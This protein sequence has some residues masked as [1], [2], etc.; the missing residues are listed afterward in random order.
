M[1]R[2]TIID[3]FSDPDRTQAQRLLEL[4][5]IPAKA[6][7]AAYFAPR[8]VGADLCK[9]LSERME[10]SEV[11][12]QEVRDYAQTILQ[13]DTQIP[14]QGPKI[15]WG[16]P[17]ADYDDD[18]TRNA[19]NGDATITMGASSSSMYSGRRS[20]TG[21]L[22]SGEKDLATLARLK[23]V[24]AFKK[25]RTASPLFA[26]HADLVF[27]HVRQ[28]GV[29]GMGII[30][31]IVD[32]RLGREAALKLI[33]HDRA[34][35]LEVWRFMREA[36]IMARLDHP[37]IPPVYEAGTDSDGQHY[38]LMR[39]IK[40]VPFDECIRR[41]HRG[42]RN[43]QQLEEYLNILVKVGEAI[44]FAH[45]EGI[46]HRDLK[47]NNIMV[48]QFGEAMVLD[49][50]LARDTRASDAK[51][52]E[53]GRPIDEDP[54][55]DLVEEAEGQEITQIGAVMGTVGYMPPEQARGHS[56]DERAD[57]FALG[58]VLSKLL[59]N[60]APFDG[61]GTLERLRATQ[62]NRVRLPVD[63]DP[64][65]SPELNAIARAALDP[66]P[67]FRTKSAHAF[68][69]DIKAYLSGYDV[70][71]YRYR[72]WEKWLRKIKRNPVPLIG[73]V[74][75]VGFIGVLIQLITVTQAASEQIRLAQE[76]EDESK[77]ARKAEARAVKAA[78]EARANEKKA[79][80]A[81]AAAKKAAE[82]A[83]TARDNALKDQERAVAE[84]KR[85]TKA[86]ED[87]LRAQS[88][89]QEEKRNADRN[90]ANLF[91]EKADRAL[92]QDDILHAEAFLSQSLSLL[93]SSWSTRRRYLNTQIGGARLLWTSPKSD[94][95]T[96]LAITHATPD[97][98]A[99][100]ATAGFTGPIGIWDAQAGKELYRLEGHKAEILSLDID[101]SG[102]YLA[103]GDAKGKIIIWDLVRGLEK[104]RLG[105][106]SEI[107][108]QRLHFVNDNQLI[109]GGL[110]KV[111][112]VNRE[113][114]EQPFIT[115]WDV[116]ERTEI[117][118]FEKPKNKVR[119]LAVHPDGELLAT[120]SRD[121][122]LNIWDLT[123]GLL[124]KTLLNPAPIIDLEFS[125]NGKVFVSADS[126]GRIAIFNG[127]IAPITSFVS[128]SA[129]VIQ[130]LSLG[131]DGRHL[132]AACQGGSV[133]HWSG[134]NWKEAQRFKRHQGELRDIAVIHSGLVAS[135][136]LDGLRL[137]ATGNKQGQF[138]S[139]GHQR[140][141]RAVAFSPNGGLIATASD[142]GAVRL[143]N[144]KT[145]RLERLLPKQG[146]AV[147]AVAFHPEGKILA[148]GSTDRLIR[149]WRVN[150]GRLLGILKGHSQALT[151]LAFSKDGERLASSCSEEGSEGVKILIW[152]VA[153]QK[154]I[155][156]L[157]HH[158]S[159][160]LAVAFDPTGR[161]LAS[162]GKDRVI[163]LWDFQTRRQLIAL[164]G[165]QNAVTSLSFGPRGLVLAS[166]SFDKSVRLWNVF[167]GIALGQLD[168]HK[169]EVTGVSFS[170]DGAFLA[171]VSHDKALRLWEVATRKSIYKLSGHLDEVTGVAFSP[172][173]GSIATVSKDRTLKLWEYSNIRLI[174]HR[175]D[176]LDVAF[177]PSG[178][179]IVSASNDR[180]LR[181]WSSKTGASRDILAGRQR[182][183]GRVEYSPDGRL[184]AWA[185]GNNTVRLTQRGAKRNIPTLSG[186]ENMVLGIAFSPDNKALASTSLDKT[187]RLWS[188]KSG[189][190]RLCFKGHTKAV[191]DVA[192]SPTNDFFVTAS[193]DRT[194]RVWNSKSGKELGRLIGHRDAVT[195][196]DVA[197][198]NSSIVIASGSDDNTVRLWSWSAKKGGQE[199]RLFRVHSAP[200]KFVSFSPGGELLASG[201]EDGTVRVFSV[202]AGRELLSLSGHN[203]KAV[204]S[205]RFGLRNG[206]LLLASAGE[207][208]IVRLWNVEKTIGG[209]AATLEMDDKKKEENARAL[210]A[211]AGLRTG[212][213]VRD[214]EL[215]PIPQ[216]YLAPGD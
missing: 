200:V 168:G 149:L 208:R 192:F 141:L 195:S 63:R 49:W 178:N 171:S 69:Q 41:Y 92:A 177:N 70:S 52:Q 140:I 152:D 68:V 74:I 21:A 213:R 146:N 124:I 184:V 26:P 6:L 46:I 54:E 183:V 17:D 94:R 34:S 205:V 130:A 126:S 51:E 50:G 38:L 214:L 167:S 1:S 185:N 135:V 71:V 121:K 4:Q 165:H 189:K 155:E 5:L 127:D 80:Q 96:V 169:E 190:E 153:D 30:H 133:Q 28:I 85:A 162:A 131:P 113:Y 180:T 3:L 216:N 136:G 156:G 60:Q 20:L 114:L 77:K 181:F 108:V 206:Q 102:N 115:L 76:A 81:Q 95:L 137:W 138:H 87:A 11:E 23:M 210:L 73:T 66:N 150:D 170:P 62:E 161:L 203:G 199:T 12:A 61:Q 97:R 44:A 43:S 144:S 198:I 186:H 79:M 90:L 106:G 110:E 56:V 13:H 57:V 145:H 212:F 176:V 204:R 112:G 19:H 40:G 22:K 72:M 55:K 104:T 59:T 25:M 18:I 164:S 9:I 154:I 99:L 116:E 143:W 31:Q 129:N 174:G 157:T 86:A 209:V 118:R 187:A 123:S 89:A 132:L 36:R 75:I 175:R 65:I 98:P 53:A 142:S 188:L 37:S 8:E 84:G 128:P 83:R 14:Q 122:R 194:L 47:P 105:N 207:D 179:E 32:K 191:S 151:S 33:R 29:G 117:T 111:P 7:R 107:E 93:P 119:C 39:V 134:G 193:W 202:Q 16:V 10:I 160:V 64:K 48:G 182:K 158:K 82:D 45:H 109:V 42:E 172:D 215:I 125:K 67:E 35:D 166:G 173:G 78:Q 147:Q 101:N 139:E 88:R 197:N 148:T 201:S 159:A 100:V 24:E 196:V 211:E 103:S 2:T 91:V 163:R 27:E 15:V 120:G 58:A